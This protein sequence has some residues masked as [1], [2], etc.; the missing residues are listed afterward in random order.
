MKEHARGH[1]ASPARC[2][3]TALPVR[4][5]L[6]SVLREGV[7]AKLKNME[8]EVDRDGRAQL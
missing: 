1:S 8:A 4:V 6:G 5:T 3:V 2:G 7:N